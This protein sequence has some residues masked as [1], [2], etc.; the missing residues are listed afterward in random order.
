MPR[1]FAAFWRLPFVF[2]NVSLIACFSSSSS[3]TP[4]KLAGS[5][6]PDNRRR[7]LLTERV[8]FCSMYGLGTIIYKDCPRESGEQGTKKKDWIPA[9]STLLRTGFA[10]MTTGT[11]FF[12]RYFDV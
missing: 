12:W 1:I 10:G 6:M 4:A 8:F 11:R 2:A 5:R 7:F 9:P 3:D